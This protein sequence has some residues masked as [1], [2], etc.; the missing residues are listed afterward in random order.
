MRG[1]AEL[2]GL[3]YK[4]VDRAVFSLLGPMAPGQEWLRQWHVGKMPPERADLIVCAALA[5]VYDTTLTALS[6]V[7][8]D[9]YA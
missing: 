6:P 8:A 2:K 4:D 5:H 3:S 1:R 9:R 7:I